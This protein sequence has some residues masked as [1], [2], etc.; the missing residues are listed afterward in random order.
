MLIAVNFIAHSFS[1]NG[2]ETRNGREKKRDKSFFLSCFHLFI[3]GIFKKKKREREGKFGEVGKDF[4]V[5]F[6]QKHFGIPKR[7]SGGYKKSVIFL[8]IKPT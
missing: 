6:K 2:M 1:T 4:F 5:T 7:K 8:S 3:G